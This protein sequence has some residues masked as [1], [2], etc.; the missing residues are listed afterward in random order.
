[1]TATAAPQLHLSP[2]H[3]TTNK[4][5]WISITEWIIDTFSDIIMVTF[6]LCRPLELIKIACQLRLVATERKTK[7]LICGHYLP[8][9]SWPQCAILT[10][11]TCPRSDCTFAYWIWFATQQIW[12]G[13]H[14]KYDIS[15]SANMI[16]RLQHTWFVLHNNY[17]LSCK[18]NMIC[19]IQLL[20]FFPVQQIW[21]VLCNAWDLCYKTNT[22][23]PTQQVWYV[24]CSTYDFSCTT[25]VICP[26]P[27]YDA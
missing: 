12:F 2:N 4:S 18:T 19:P 17:D 14:W 16:C 26:V 7:L 5:G 11:L 24:L 21:C 1:M 20:W 27:V 13:L 10:I 9:F 6:L 15:C 25:N 3:H 23:C 8:I 22:T